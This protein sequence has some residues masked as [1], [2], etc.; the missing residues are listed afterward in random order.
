MWTV[1]QQQGHQ[2]DTRSM[3]I[4]DP[5]GDMANLHVYLT[6]PKGDTYVLKIRKC[7]VLKTLGVLGTR[8]RGWEEKGSQTLSYSALVQT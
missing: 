7:S 8:D 6:R 3:H 1:A 4:S 2:L 5:T